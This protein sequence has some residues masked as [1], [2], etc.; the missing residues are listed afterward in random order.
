MCLLLIRGYTSSFPA[1][2]EPGADQSLLI[3]QVLEFTLNKNVIL[4]VYSNELEFHD[5]ISRR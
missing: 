5:S 3:R 1:W 4:I 2:R